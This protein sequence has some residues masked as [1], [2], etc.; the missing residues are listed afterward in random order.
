MSLPA[1]GIWDTGGMGNVDADA[2]EC[3]QRGRVL[4]MPARS[5]HFSCTDRR[6]VQHLAYKTP[7]HPGSFLS[8]GAGSISLSVL[9]HFTLKRPMKVVAPVNN[10]SIDGAEGFLFVK[11][12]GG[13]P[14]Q[15]S[16]QLDLCSVRLWT[17]CG[18]ARRA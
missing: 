6:R 18:P 9:F 14:D 4:V 2:K 16:G 15:G 11:P 5:S 3:L 7:Q 17:G 12:A 13:L 8:G 1:N 10:R